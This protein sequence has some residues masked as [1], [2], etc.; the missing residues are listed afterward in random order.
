MKVPCLGTTSP[1]SNL[2]EGHNSYVGDLCTRRD[3]VAGAIRDAIEKYDPQL[4]G[5]SSMTFQYGTAKKVARLIREI[6]KDITLVLGGYHATLM[7]PEVRTDEDS[8]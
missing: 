2:S 8:K 5:L 7:S 1:A 4:I 6:N 3:D